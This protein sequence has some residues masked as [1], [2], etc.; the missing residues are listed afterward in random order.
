MKEGKD[1]SI[2][3]IIINMLTQQMGEL[4]G[5]EEHLYVLEK[6]GIK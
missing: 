2:I 3:R 4:C 6:V 5:N 1:I